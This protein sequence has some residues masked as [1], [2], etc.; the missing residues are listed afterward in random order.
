MR[1]KK[2][3]IFITFLIIGIGFLLWNFGFFNRYNYLTAKSDIASNNPQI[4]FIGESMLT[5]S[6]INTV[7]KKYGF[8]VVNFDRIVN[9]SEQ[10]GIEIYN[11]Q[12]DNYLDKL[13]GI[14]WE[15]E[16]KKEIDSLM[17]LTNIPK[18]AFWIEKDASGNWFNVDWMH[19]HKNNAVISIYDKYGNLIVKSKFMKTCPIDELKFIEDLKTE[20]DFYDGENIQLKDN[21]YLLK[22]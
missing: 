2:N 4:I 7:S 17:K 11:S 15:T 21:C 9:Q 5:Y 19:N 18:T 22:D 12:M 1:K 3:L 8:K 10:N 13:N 20:I 6:D 16:Y 14:G